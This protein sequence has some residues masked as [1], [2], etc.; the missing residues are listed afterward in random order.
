MDRIRPVY[1]KQKSSMPTTPAATP[2]APSS[3]M[4]SP[5]P[6]R[7][8]RSGS[9]AGGSSV[10]KAQTKA[11]AQRLAAVMAHKPTDEDVD[12]D[13]LSFDYNATGTAG[14]G[15]AGGRAV[16]PRSPVVI[17]FHNLDCFV[18]SGFGCTKSINQVCLPPRI[19][20]FKGY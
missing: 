7:H 9:V 5:M 2:G 16:R 3:P 17:H 18:S 11:A 4:I 15:L 20:T 1:T 10:R 12:E 6:R 8:V 13:D 19:G 14:I